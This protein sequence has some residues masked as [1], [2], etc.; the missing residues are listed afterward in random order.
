MPGLGPHS[1]E[2][3]QSAQ[4]R[5]NLSDDFWTQFVIIPDGKSDV[6]RENLVVV[7]PMRVSHGS[8]T[9]CR[10]L[11]APALVALVVFLSLGHAREA[12]AQVPGTEAVDAALA[13]AA[14]GAAPAEATQLG[15][16]AAAVSQ[17][18]AA[19]AAA[20]QAQPANV[21]V[22]AAPALVEQ[23]NGA[24]AGADAT[25]GN[26]VAQELDQTQAAGAGGRS[27]G[28]PAQG[29]A[30]AQGA[31]PS[32]AAG[33]Q[34]VA[35]QNQP[36]NIAIPVVVNS[37]NSHPVV[38]QTNNAAPAANAG[39][40]SSIAQGASQVQLGG[41]NTGGAAAG[42]GP[43]PPAP[44]AEASG[45]PL[46]GPPAQTTQEAVGGPPAQAASVWIWVWNWTWDWK[47]SVPEVAAPDVSVPSIGGIA[48]GKTWPPKLD[49]VSI[50]DELA[51]VAD[52]VAS[53][54]DAIAPVADGLA[55]SPGAAIVSALPWLAGPV[56]AAAEDGQA[57]G[58]RREL[59]AR[60]SAAPSVAGG[61][62]SGG[63]IGPPLVSP[64]SS[65]FVQS[66]ASERKRRERST[67]RA[68]G[69]VP[70]PLPRHSA[71]AGAGGPGI[72]PAGLVLGALLLLA[73]QLASVAFALGRRFDL[74]SAAWR[75][76]AY[77]SPLERPG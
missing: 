11:V 12:V 74:A 50:V 55:A 38:T 37:P 58:G 23:M 72:S 61:I 64:L 71:P 76:Q 34:A 4:R 53:V 70:P 5:R 9:S 60:G 16:Q 73:L 14:L 27:G 7:F 51:A 28:N 75:R 1:R 47:V 8:R 17:A 49:A 21:A 69:P 46:G 19:E 63:E 45:S 18:A 26:A 13:D 42:P 2:I 36:I 20:L 59:P 3:V 77:L 67:Q 41:L 48:P 24:A 31:Q 43:A 10:P 57:R 15:E 65:T 22:P 39:N 33:A 25:N 30:A 52:D 29:Q 54:V 62:P 44:G 40:T 32:Q 56:P 66:P 68:D 6:C 35:V